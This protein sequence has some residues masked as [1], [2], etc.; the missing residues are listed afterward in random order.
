MKKIA[1]IGSTG[2]IGRQTIEVVASH[3]ERFCIVAMAAGGSADLFEEQ[4]NAV[5]PKYAALCNG[6]AAKRITN[7]PAGTQFFGGQEAALRAASYEEA[8]IVVVAA[9]GFAGLR[10]S[11][12][13]IQAGK[14]LALANKETLVCGGDFVLPLAKKMGVTVLPVDSEHSAIWQCLNFQPHVAFRSLI[15]T[16]SGGAFRGWNREQLKGVTAAQALAHPTWQMGP[17]ITVDSATLLNKGFEVIE[18]HHLFGADYSDIQTVIHPQSIVHSMVEF[19]DGAVMAQLSHPSMLLPIQMALTYPERLDCPLKRLSVKE[20]FALQFMPLIRQDY[21]CFDIALSCGQKGGTAPTV[22]N[23]AGEEAVYAFLRGE[24][25]FLAIS[26]VLQGV[27]DESAVFPVEGYEQLTEVDNKA[28]Q[29]AR[30]L[31]KN[32]AM[33]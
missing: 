27:L 24:L 26:E 10:Y 11:L 15:I 22:L 30:R 28:R 7:I 19:A 25:P 3:P 18:A 32:I 1:L 21:P 31:I 6:E 17:K 33:K 23:A 20:A 2:S 5:K 16:A 12:A 13:A 9:S 4:I 8:D 14:Q 29:C